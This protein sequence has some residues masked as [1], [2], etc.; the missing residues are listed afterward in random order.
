SVV[1]RHL[2]QHIGKDLPKTAAS[3]HKLSPFDLPNMRSLQTGW[4]SFVSRPRG[5]FLSYPSTETSRNPVASLLTDQ[6]WTSFIGAR[7]TSSTNFLRANAP[8]I[9]LSNNLRFSMS[10]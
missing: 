5:G 6:S 1:Y 7:R 8:V 3:A 2:W 10:S 9:C 4:K